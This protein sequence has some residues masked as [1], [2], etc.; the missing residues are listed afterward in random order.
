MKTN[1]ICFTK[2]KF[3]FEEDRER[4]LEKKYVGN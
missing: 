3:K 2:Q 4:N 1:P